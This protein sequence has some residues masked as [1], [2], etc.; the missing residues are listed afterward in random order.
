VSKAYAQGWQMLRA[1]AA[2]WA[3]LAARLQQEARGV[4]PWLGFALPWALPVLATLVL[5]LGFVGLRQGGLGFKYTPLA[6][7]G[8]A[9]QAV[10]LG[11]AAQWLL[12]Q[13]AQRLG[14]RFG[15]Q[16]DGRYAAA[17]VVHAAMPLWAL[18]LLMIW[19]G[20]WW[21]APLA[22]AWAG[23]LLHGGLRSLMRP[24]AERAVAYTTSVL[25]AAALLI[26]LLGALGRCTTPALQP[27]GEADP[28]WVELFQREAP[29]AQA[30]RP[31]ASAVA[32]AQ[33]GQGGGGGER[34]G[35]ARPDAAGQADGVLAAA[36]SAAS[37]AG[38]QG[39]GRTG[40][41]PMT[42]SVLQ[43]FLLPAPSGYERRNVE[44]YAYTG[45]AGTLQATL[46]NYALARAEYTGSAGGRRVLEIKDLSD[47]G[48]P[49][50][51]KLLDEVQRTGGQRLDDDGVSQRQIVLQGDGPA[52]RV[53]LR[54]HHAAAR[55]GWLELIVGQRYLVRAE[56]DGL[57]AEELQAWAQ[58]VNLAAL[59][60]RVRERKPIE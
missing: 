34:V 55:R 22:L 15:T 47:I 24:P 3:A 58:Q 32:Q 39:L 44:S 57:S 41:E 23:W 1:P 12:A 2:A 8:V 20:L 27:T 21:L 29:L 9:L 7:L 52:E 28:A 26:L 51:N 25:L 37:G 30:P 13:L 35:L 36:A 33:E 56:A 50:V 17:A 53:W 6:A 16:G 46:G 38:L 59:E 40:K 42:R 4:R 5:G 11:L 18:G 31:A 19:P 45:P 14:P 49:A 54:S 48:P 43:D 10:A 60:A